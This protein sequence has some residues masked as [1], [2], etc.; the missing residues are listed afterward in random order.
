MQPSLFYRWQKQHSVGAGE[1]LTRGLPM[2]ALSDKI[3]PA[4]VERQSQGIL[5]HP[6]LF[7]R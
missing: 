1:D 2:S 6:D 3:K 4:R 7:L 5:T